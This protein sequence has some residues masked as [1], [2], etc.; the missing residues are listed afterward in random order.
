MY[1]MQIKI[2]YDN[3]IININIDSKQ[4]YLFLKW[5]CQMDRNRHKNFIN[6]LKKHIY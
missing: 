6:Q 2:L 3:E 1:I 5:I 4:K